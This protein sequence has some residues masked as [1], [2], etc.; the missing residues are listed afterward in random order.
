MSNEG[1][2]LYNRQ[3]APA[4]N[5]V[6]LM[7]VW[8]MFCCIASAI[9]TVPLGNSAGIRLFGYIVGNISRYYDP[10]LVGAFATCVTYLSS[11]IPPNG[12]KGMNEVTAAISG[13]GIFLLAFTVT[14]AMN[15]GEIF[16]R[17]G[18]SIGYPSALTIIILTPF[19]M[20]GAILTTG[21][22][23]IALYFEKGPVPAIL[24]VSL[25]YLGKWANWW[26][27]NTIRH[28]FTGAKS[29][30]KSSGEVG[31]VVQQS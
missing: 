9:D 14:I 24:F 21:M 19:G 22:S 11:K 25:V 10:F 29:A 15:Y 4:I 28:G 6:I 20:R 13:V 26:I 1:N 12:Y 18:C 30:L 31:A 7:L 16:Q 2:A 17:I 8:S 23:L 3:T 5:G 27:F